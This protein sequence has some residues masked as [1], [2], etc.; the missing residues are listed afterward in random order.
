MNMKKIV[1]LILAVTLLAASVCAVADGAW[2]VRTSVSA[3]SIDRNARRA[4]SEAME[5]YAGYAVRPLALLGTQVV[6]GVN[7]CFLG[8][9][10]AATSRPAGSLCKVYVYAGPDGR[11]E[12]AGIREIPLKGAPASG[13]EISQ[14]RRALKV[15]AAAKA[16]LRQATEEMTGA[17]YKP[18]LVLARAGSGQ[19]GYALLCRRRMTDRRG[20]AGLSIVTLRRTG[21]RYAVRRAEAL[22][23][24]K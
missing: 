24:E 19:Q 23:V 5:G 7:Y 1:A 3:M 15:E 16:A 8:Y 4:F 20:S 21:G 18:L 2:S 13:W 17:T 22:K 14:S 12:L 9:G 11:A 10:T 6:A